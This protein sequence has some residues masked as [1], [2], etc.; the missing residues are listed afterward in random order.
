MEKIGVSFSIN[1]SQIE[2]ERLYAGKKGKYL[3]CTVFIDPTADQYGQNGMI[4][5]S[6]SKEEKAQGVKGPILGN[7]KIFWTDG[8]QQQQ[9][10]QQQPQQQPADDFIGDEIPF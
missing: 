3:D 4:V 2:K 9:P 6:V 7:C 1:V 10:Q 5:Q 8:Q